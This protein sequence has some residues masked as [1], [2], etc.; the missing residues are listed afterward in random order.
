MANNPNGIT[1]TKP[2]TD[3]QWAEMNT[4]LTV[5]IPQ[6]EDLLNRSKAAGLDVS[7][8]MQQLAASKKQ[9]QSMIDAFK[10]IYK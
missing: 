6:H 5:T 3:Q 7:A 9:L 4:M 1:P 8:A 2:F 10:D